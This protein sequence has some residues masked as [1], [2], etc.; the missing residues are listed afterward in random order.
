MGERDNQGSDE[1]KR[2]KPI[3]EKV[4]E[5]LKSFPNR[6]RNTVT[7]VH[8]KLNNVEDIIQYLQNIKVLGN[9]LS[10]GVLAEMFKN[11]IPK[12][13]EPFP[14]AGVEGKIVPFRPD[15]SVEDIK[16]KF[17]EL[18]DESQKTGQPIILL[19]SRHNLE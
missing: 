12:S 15:M 4:S 10:L 6:V 2:E 1:N 19:K 17:V 8:A 14:S 16:T 18:I 11:M 7:D 3:N 5:F 13:G 9:S